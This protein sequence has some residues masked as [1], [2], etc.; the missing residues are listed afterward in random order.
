MQ[1]AEEES[2]QGTSGDAKST[3]EKRTPCAMRRRAWHD[4]RGGG[5]GSVEVGGSKGWQTS[6]LPWRW[7]T[8][9]PKLNGVGRRRSDAG[10]GTSECMPPKPRHGNSSPRAGSGTLHPGHGSVMGVAPGGQR[11]PPTPNDGGCDAIWCFRGHGTRR[12]RGEGRGAR[13]EGAAG[14]GGWAERGLATQITF[15][16][17]TAAWPTLARS[18][19]TARKRGGDLLC[20][21]QG[22]H[23]MAKP[24]I[25]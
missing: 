7:F 23:A 16:S 15:S 19:P 13:A 11:H 24:Q 6:S 2:S 25:Q 5:R 18:V 22:K 20:R 8:G 3:E 17:K 4:G 21:K 10:V 9:T 14:G 1:R 12:G